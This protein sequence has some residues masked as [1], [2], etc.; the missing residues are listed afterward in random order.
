MLTQKIDILSPVSE[1]N[2][3][4]EKIQRY[5]KTYSTRA[6]VTDQNGQRTLENNEIFYLYSKT[7]QVRSYV[8]VKDRD[9]IKYK[10]KQYRI[11]NIEDRR[12]EE[13]DKIIYAELVN[14]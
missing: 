5:D 14:G 7:F 13:N 1:V 2:E 8:P 11:M 12:E 4:G 6:R 9:Y 10:G 3:Y